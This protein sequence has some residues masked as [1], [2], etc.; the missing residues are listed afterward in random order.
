MVTTVTV[1][2]L[3]TAFGDLLKRAKSTANANRDRAI[4][5]DRSRAALFIKTGLELQREL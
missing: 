1:P 4:G 2:S 5:T 3:A